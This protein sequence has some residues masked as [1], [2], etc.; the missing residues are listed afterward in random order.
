M[1]VNLKGRSL[2]TLKDFTPQE[3]QLLLNLS[4]D[5]KKKKQAGIEGSILKN[6]N[7]V[8]IFEKSSTRTRC[9]FEVAVFDEGGNV[10]FLTNSHMGKKEA[11]QDTARVLGR[12]Y[13]GIEFRGFEQK[14]AEGLAKYSGVPVWNGL[15]DMYHPTQVLADFL[16]I[17]EQVNKPLNKVN[18]VYIGDARNNIGNSLLI[19]AAKTGM[20]YTAV[21]PASLK[22]EAS[23]IKEMESV[24]SETGATLSFTED[25]KKGVKGADVIYT[26]VWVSMGEED[27]FDQ[28]IKLLLPYQISMDVIKNTE[29]NDVIFMHDLPAF[30]DLNTTLAK[31]VNEKYGIKEMEVTDEVFESKHSVVFDQAENRMHTIKAVM[32]ATIGDL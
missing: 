15:T 8:I 24:A 2:L 7:I 9:A 3:I 29:N 4:L 22:Q 12:F 20:N 14:T 25:I 6:K 10:S 18:F 28:R 26:D 31:D 17:M 1:P 30:H 5:L 16:T 23:L 21:S 13:D 11:I 27:M 32:C 19:G